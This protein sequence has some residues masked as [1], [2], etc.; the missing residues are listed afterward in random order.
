MSVRHAALLGALTSL[1]V[2]G[3]SPTIVW[4][5][6]GFDIE[7]NMFI[8]GPTETPQRAPGTSVRPWNGNASES[9]AVSTNRYT[10]AASSA[11]PGRSPEYAFD[12]NVRTWWQPASEDRQPWLMLDLGCRNPTDPNQEF[13]IDSTRI[14]FDTAPPER[15]AFNVDGHAGWFPNSRGI[16]P[17]V[18]RYKIETSLDNH[19]YLT[20]IDRTANSRAQ[21]VEFV[22]FP[23]VRC[24][25]VKVSLIRDTENPAPPVLEFTVFGTPAP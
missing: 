15:Q 10:G 25:Y 8:A 23:P 12:N 1:L 16:V 19:I 4:D 22:E 6:V 17:T 7:G 2:F 21:N 13:T 18:Y 24:R 3:Q 11:R 20:A 9:I 14:L 5:P